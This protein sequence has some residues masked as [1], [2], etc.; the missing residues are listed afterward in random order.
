MTALSMSRL[1]VRRL[2]PVSALTAKLVPL[3]SE[4][5]H[6]KVPLSASRRKAVTNRSAKFAHQVNQ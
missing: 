6:V 3:T 4:D 1:R 5:R 2:K